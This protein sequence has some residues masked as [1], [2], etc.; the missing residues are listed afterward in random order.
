MDE[1]DDSFSESEEQAQDSGQ[2]QAGVSAVSPD[3]NASSESTE[4]SSCNVHYVVTAA[5]ECKLSD[6]P[7]QECKHSEL[8]AKLEPPSF[9]PSLNCHDSHHEE[10]VSDFNRASVNPA[11]AVAEGDCFNASAFESARVMQAQT[12]SLGQIDSHEAMQSDD[13]FV[14]PSENAGKVSFDSSSE[15]SAQLVGS[16][17]TVLK[18]DSVAGLELNETCYESTS[19]IAS[20]TTEQTY[21]VPKLHAAASD[22]HAAALDKFHAAALNRLDKAD[23]RKCELSGDSPT[24][25]SLSVC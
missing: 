5:E 19:S 2:Q 11:P 8:P 23:D 25:V 4:H 10:N 14:S 18:S 3:H 9:P 24:K 22:S 20:G 15:A 21:V 6:L 12:L 7:P 16:F 17:E 1:N 13:Q